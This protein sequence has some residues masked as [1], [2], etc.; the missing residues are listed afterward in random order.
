MLNIPEHLV[1]EAVEKC[2][3][4]FM[5]I[6][7]E[8]EYT[9][10]DRLSGSDMGTGE[11]T[12]VY[13]GICSACGYVYDD[14]GEPPSEKSKKELKYGSC[15]CGMASYGRMYCPSC[16]AELEM[17]KGWLGRKSI[18]EFF[19]LYAWEVETYDKAVLYEAYIT[20]LDYE[21]CIEN[22]GPEWIYA[23]NEQKTILT[24]NGAE[25]YQWSY[26]SYDWYKV[27][28]PNTLRNLNYTPCVVGAD[29]LENSFLNHLYNYTC[30]KGLSA[31]HLVRF[32][33]EPITEL[34]HKA[35]FVELAEKRVY[36]YR[37][38]KGTPHID[39]TVHSPKKMFRGLKKNH[40][41]QKMKQLLK[42]ISEPRYI[43]ADVLEAAACTFRDCKTAKP[44]NMAEIINTES[45][46]DARR[47]LRICGILS[48]FPPERVVEYALSH[49]P[50]IYMDYLEAAKENGAPLYERGTAFPDDLIEAHA[51]Q[52]GKRDYAADPETYD[53]C[54]KRYEQ[55]VSAGYEYEW[56]GIYS[57]IPKTPR[58]IKNEGLALCHCV[59]TYV[60]SHVNGKTNIIFIRRR[61]KPDSWFTLEVDPQSL[62]FKQCYGFKNKT[63]GLKF[64]RCDNYDPLVGQFLENYTR[65][66]K[67]AKEHKKEMKQRCR[68]TV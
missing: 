7:P 6:Y 25:T 55:L 57:V 13:Y 39:F 41:G 20:L 22:A 51:A 17:R 47:I 19:H 49:N 60:D 53:K 32:I 30:A 35:G 43:S 28:K 45:P 56:H 15:G 1:R 16:G 68:I 5:L 8:R 34:F 23:R 52:T 2:G 24:P 36:N 65:R 58:D 3:P 31:Q 64:S 14:I 59:E 38:G 33:D 42:L 46:E 18:R 44:E 62:S 40:A 11:K 61:E 50:L 37:A 67:W 63:S 27:K 48:M 66:L 4:K 26:W 21:N 10:L 9:E 12:G 54:E 29:K